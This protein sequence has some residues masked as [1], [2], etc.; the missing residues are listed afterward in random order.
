MQS[1]PS[2]R[3]GR[4]ETLP[5]KKRAMNPVVVIHLIAAFVAIIVA[6]PLARRRVKMNQWYGVRIPAAF[7]SE[8]AW[9]DINQYGSR[10]LIVW[11]AVIAATAF[12]GAF[13]KRSAWLAYDWTA[14]VIVIA[15]LLFVVRSVYRYARHRKMSNQAPLPTPVSVTPA[16]NAPVAPP[17]GVAGL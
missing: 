14:L 5:G 13:L 9:F 4:S 16:A 10:L 17:P 6:V 3:R 12:V 7:E 15:G 1:N 8:D 11:G 2:A